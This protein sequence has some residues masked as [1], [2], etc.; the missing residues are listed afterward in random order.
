MSKMTAVALQLQTEKKRKKEES[1][2][3]KHVSQGMK[4]PPPHKATSFRNKAKES[5]I[6]ITKECVWY[7]RYKVYGMV[8][9]VRNQRMPWHPHPFELGFAPLGLDARR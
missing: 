8:G 2:R 3:V 4:T 1:V 5:S 7:I 6:S 9:E